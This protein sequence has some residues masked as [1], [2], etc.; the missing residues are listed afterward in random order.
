MHPKELVETVETTEDYKTFHTIHPDYYLA[1][2]FTLGDEWKVAYYSP[3]EDKM[4]TFSTNPVKS[5]EPEDV[6]KKDNTVKKLEM[7]EVKVG[8]EAVN[9]ACEVL[10]AAKYALHPVTKKIIVLQ[11]HDGLMYNITMMTGTLA[12]IN[13][14][15]DAK[16]GELI[17]DAVTSAMSFQK[18]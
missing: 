10:H 4:V 14:K 2:V 9:K 5:G 3:E 1:M 7:K 6:F 18:E 16:T 12:V 11:N 8:I 15:I 13:I 17:S